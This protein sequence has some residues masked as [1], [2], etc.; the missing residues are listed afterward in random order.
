MSIGL[1]AGHAAR[2]QQAGRPVCPLCGGSSHFELAARDLNRR[3]TSETFDY[4]RCESCASLFLGEPPADLAS[5]YQ[6]EYYQ[7][8]SDGEALWRHEPPLIEAA[9]W[10]VASL[11]AFVPAGSLIDVGAGT[12]AF[13]A[14]AS[15]AGFA[16]TAIEM[17]ATCC[18]YIEQTLGIRA[19]CSDRPAEE[20]GSLS[21]AQVVTFWHV[22]EHVREP[23]IALAAAAA[24]LQPGGI[25]ALALPNPE[26]LQFRVLRSRWPHLDAPRHLNLMP[27]SAIVEQARELGLQPVLATTNDPD[28]LVANLHGWVYAL[29]RN[30]MRPDV[31]WP[32][33]YA[34]LYLTR[35][36]SAIERRGR[37]GAALTVFLR[38]SR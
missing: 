19:I 9:Q 16:V 3:I 35:A 15:S 8:D 28:G 29:R 2:R 36:L 21:G 10:R 34:G 25:L 17:D 11:R 22:L 37:R 24:S 33:A 6:R 1:L 20:L 14:A 38:K 13:A 4:E 7:F 18:S 5:Y 23:H 32:T 31:W 27:A 30:R 12:G 26:S